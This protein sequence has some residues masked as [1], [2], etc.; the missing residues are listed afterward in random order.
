MKQAELRLY[1]VIIQVGQKTQLHIHLSPLI[2][3]NIQGELK[4]YRGE[5]ISYFLEKKGLVESNNEEEHFVENI[6]KLLCSSS[7]C[8]DEYNNKKNFIFSKSL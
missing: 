8:W 1:K 4:H 2:V 6:D 5:N 7:S 3:H